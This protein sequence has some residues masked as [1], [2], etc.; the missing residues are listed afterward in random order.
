MHGF[1]K[2]NPEASEMT[3]AAVIINSVPLP[4]NH[5]PQ[6]I[7]AT[8]TRILSQVTDHT[9]FNLISQRKDYLLCGI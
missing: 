8:N 2:V 9:R 5:Q 7:D 6:A 3:C 4:A 1:A